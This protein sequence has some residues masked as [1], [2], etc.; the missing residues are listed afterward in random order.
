MLKSFLLN[1]ILRRF[2]TP[3]H[4][5]LRYSTLLYATLRYSTLLYATLRYSTLLYATLRHSIFNFATFQTFG[6][7]IM[8]CTLLKIRVLKHLLFK[9]LK[10]EIDMLYGC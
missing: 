6:S 8:F 7:T 4:A 3:R 1:S 5:T 2:D 10:I 9:K